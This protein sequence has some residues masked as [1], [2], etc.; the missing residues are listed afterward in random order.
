MNSH[1]RIEDPYF[2]EFI[3]ILCERNDDFTNRPI[4]ISPYFGAYS[5]PGGLVITV[6]GTPPKATIFLPLSS[7]K[8]IIDI[9]PIKV[10]PFGNDYNRLIGFLK[11][12]EIDKK[13]KI[14]LK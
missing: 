5:K 9:Q 6:Q 3:Y 7:Y 1:Q 13:Y 10:V 8:A 14:D 12:H 4:I 2:V 11:R